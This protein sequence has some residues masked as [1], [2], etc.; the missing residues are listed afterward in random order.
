MRVLH[1]AVEFMSTTSRMS[2]PPAVK[3]FEVSEMVQGTNATVHGVVTELSP[4]KVSRNNPNTKYFSGKL[5]DGKKLARVISF[6]P[7]L[8]PTM[9][10]SRKEQSAIA[11][12]NCTIQENK[13]D[14]D[15]EVMAS[16]HTTIQVSP[17]KIKL[18]EQA[19]NS[20]TNVVHLGE[21]AE[22][23]VNQLINVA[24][25][26]VKVSGI[27]NLEV[28]SKLLKKQDCRVSDHTDTIRA[29]LW[30]NN[31]DK[32]QE[33]KSYHLIQFR[34]R[35][36]AC[37]KY[38]SMSESSSMIEVD[39]IG[40]VVNSDGEDDISEGNNVI[41]G[42]IVVV[43]NVTTYSSCPRCR[44]KV[45]T[46]SSISGECIKCKAKVK[47]SRVKESHSAKFM[48]EADNKKTEYLTAFTDELT[49]IIEGEEGSTIEDKMLSAAPMKFFWDGNNV[50][51]AVHK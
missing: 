1:A 32:L 43:L 6:Q 48:V 13:Y 45:I 31:C 9:E 34:V 47:M 5:S 44:G 15:L 36:Y 41:E 23:N 25:K 4:I 18:D 7:Q 2:Q 29:V 51:R 24:C 35:E 39:D 27:S 11:M 14:S 8:R 19:S 38:L 20:C 21:I 49:Q 3:V 37:T 28:K 46:I 22:L 40:E 42:E 50:V 26:I 30:E 16:S 33:G 17:K 12:V 10:E